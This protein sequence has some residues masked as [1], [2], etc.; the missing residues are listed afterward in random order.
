MNYE[1]AKLMVYHAAWLKDNDLPHSKE[2][3]SA[4]MFAV[5]MACKVVDEVT[6]IYGAYGFAMEYPAQRYFRDARF[7]LY[8]GG[9]HEILKT[10]I[11]RELTGRL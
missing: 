9:T 4:K 3:A 2:A 5:E 7:L 1:A 11:A 10:V 6:R 8:G